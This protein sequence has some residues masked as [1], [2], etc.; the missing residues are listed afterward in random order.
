LQ[1]LMRLRV[2]TYNIRSGTDMLGRPRLNEQAAVVRGTAPDLVLLQEVGS[3]EQA[4]R[5]GSLVRLPHVTFGA[6]RTT[7]RGEFGN[8]L[9]CRWPLEDVENHVV[10]AGWPLSQARTVLA[11]TANAD[12]RRIHAL[13]AHFGLLPGEPELSTRVVLS[14]AAA[15]DGALIVGGDLNRP[16]AGAACHRTL[17]GV[18]MDAAREHSRLAEPTFPAPWP[19]LRLDYVYVRDLLVQAVCVVPS[20]VSDHRPV[21]ADVS[22]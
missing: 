17:R 4:E 9:L 13:V 3:R 7:N 15:R 21:L 6:A 10:A 14:A 5:L 11:A 12:G 2:L 16:L 1:A 18:L 19:L 22:T 20:S 8:A